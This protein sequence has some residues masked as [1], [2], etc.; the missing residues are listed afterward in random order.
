M[1]YLAKVYPAIAWPCIFT[2]YQW[3]ICCMADPLGCRSQSG[4]VSMG[5]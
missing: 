1:K 2:Y 3:N 4:T 5:C